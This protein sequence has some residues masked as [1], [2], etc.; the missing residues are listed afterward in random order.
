MI[1]FSNRKS[2]RGMFVFPELLLIRK[3]II[4]CSFNISNNL[5]RINMKTKLFYAGRACFTMAG[6]K[7][8]TGSVRAI[9][10]SFFSFCLLVLL[11]ASG[12]AAQPIT[13]S[14]SKDGWVLDKTVSN[15][16]FYYRIA[17]CNNESV[18]F[19]KLENRNDFPAKV[20]WEEVYATRQVPEKRNGKNGVKTMLLPAGITVQDNCENIVHRECIILPDEVSS[21]Y[22]AI[23]DAF[24]FTSVRVVSE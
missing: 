16:D 14:D 17:T 6:F 1:V 5:K 15:V 9:N 24:E 12:F 7:K 20:S 11:S 22:K 21:S 13:P 19:L 8:L 4:I 23:V 2:F 10:I 18:V 3:F